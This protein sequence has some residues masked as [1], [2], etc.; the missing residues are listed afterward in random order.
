M[1]NNFPGLKQA[2]ALMGAKTALAVDLS[3]KSLLDSDSLLAERVRETEKQIDAMCQ[4]INEYCLDTISTGAFSRQQINFT[5]NSL[6]IALELERIGDY[7]NQIAKM[8]QRKLSQQDIKKFRVCDSDIATMK[9][10]SLSMLTLALKAYAE[11]DSKAV[12]AIRD[13]DCQVD[14]KNKDLFRNMICLVSVNPWLQEA[15]MD[16]HTVVRYI[17]R[18]ADR[19]TNIAELTYYILR[20]EPIKKKDIPAQ[21]WNDD[22]EKWSERHADRP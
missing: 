9:D 21:L 4:V 22:T 17:E 10:Q 11:A 20:G 5:V 1:D 14:K 12:K 19:A 7:A 8:V 16:Y 6:K 13:S 2:V 18:V 15:A 3:V